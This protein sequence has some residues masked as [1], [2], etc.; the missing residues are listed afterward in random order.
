[1]NASIIFAPK[2]VRD[3]WYKH[4]FLFSQSDIHLHDKETVGPSVMVPGIPPEFRNKELAP[5]VCTGLGDCNRK[6]YDV[7]YERL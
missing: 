6:L 3:Y 5:A 4:G 1:M 7:R 2:V